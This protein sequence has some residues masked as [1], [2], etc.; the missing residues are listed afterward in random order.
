MDNRS[1]IKSI[2]NALDLSQSELSD[3]IDVPAPTV[4]AYEKNTRKLPAEVAKNISGLLAKQGC[5]IHADEIRSAQWLCYMTK[6]LPEVTDSEK[7]TK[8]K[9][10]ILQNFHDM[11]SKIE[12]MET[13][14]ELK[15]SAER[16]RRKIDEALIRLK[17]WANEPETKKTLSNDD[18]LQKVMEPLEKI[19]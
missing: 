17:N 16:R 3:R 10:N 7:G 12:G 4:A 18:G 8:E 19:G 1:V 5:D 15:K 9:I 2:R 13:V 14:D 6:R 11:L